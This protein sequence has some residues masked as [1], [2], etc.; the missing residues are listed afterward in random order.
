LNPSAHALD[1]LARGS[2]AVVIAALLVL[3]LSLAPGP[4]RAA[5]PIG[6]DWPMWHHDQAH[7]GVSP[8]TQIGASNVAG[9]A[10][11]WQADIAGSY[12]SP[13]VVYNASLD[14]TLV[15]VGN[16]NGTFSAYDAVTGDR[17]WYYKVPA[18][19]Q[20]S[21][22]VDG[23]VVYFGAN[24]HNLYALNA[25][26]GGFICR[27]DVGGLIDSSPVV[28]DPDG[29]GKVVYLG[30]AGLS[31]SDDGGA[32]FAINAVDPNP[33]ADCSVRWS[34]NSFGDPPGS[35]PLVGSW[36]PPAFGR[37]VN[38]RAVVVFGGSS[39]E[40]AVYALY[41]VTGTRIWRYQTQLFTMDQDVGAGPTLSAPGVNGF[42]DGVAYVAGK[43]SILYAFDL[44]TGALIWTSSFRGGR[45]GA[46]RSTAALVGRTLYV[47]NGVGP[48]VMAVD[49]VTGARVW[50]G[51]DSGTGEVISS[52]AVTGA[53][54]DQVLFAGDTNGN[55]YGQSLAT[56]ALLWK[57]A[58]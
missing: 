5:G 57:Y 51:F 53:P 25:T 18:P 3:P 21:P 46:T 13:V 55:L 49:A 2:A 26:T 4:V 8:D 22:A 30:D 28:A 9:L 17:V 34:Y 44:T 1:R 29:G 33:A 41:A 45:H 16:N 40:G 56:G 11:R 39:P 37:D 7:S 32:F 48:D 12:T 31:G 43:D 20:S 35:Q 54:G 24:D 52:P 23:N 15:Y 42:A 14:R 50:T 19:I 27:L 38:G 6:A 58:T 10:L 36:S 47:G